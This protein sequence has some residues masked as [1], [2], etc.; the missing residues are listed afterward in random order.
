MTPEEAS[1]VK[2][3]SGPIPGLV[4]FG[5]IPSDAMTRGRRRFC[6]GA[7]RAHRES[8]GIKDNT[9]IPTRKDKNATLRQKRHSLCT[10]CALR[11][12]S[13]VDEGLQHRA[14]VVTHDKIG[15]F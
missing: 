9:D 11:G 5:S 6:A 14:D 8:F 7:P 1:S 13:I 10:M 3:D 12:R 15:D 2:A 4:D